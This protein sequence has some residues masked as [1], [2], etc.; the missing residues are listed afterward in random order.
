MS[1]T[2]AGSAPLP[3]VRLVDN[4]DASWDYVA[5]EGQQFTLKTNLDAPR[6]RCGCSR[7]LNKLWLHDTL[8]Q[9]ST[10]SS[11]LFDPQHRGSNSRL[12]YG[13]TCLLH[14]RLP[15]T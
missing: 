3:L 10:A 14:P 11:G 4:F 9:Q 8:G 7:G 1:S 12:I 15:S 5:N 13:L 2:C 6:Y